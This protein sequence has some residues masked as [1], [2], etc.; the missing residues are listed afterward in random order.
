MLDYA[1]VMDLYNQNNIRRCVNMYRRTDP[2]SYKKRLKPWLKYFWLADKEHNFVD[3]KRPA[4]FEKGTYDASSNMY[5]L[6]RE[7]DLT[8]KH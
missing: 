8:G 7:G 6:L 2:L 4:L 3:H 5:N 1:G